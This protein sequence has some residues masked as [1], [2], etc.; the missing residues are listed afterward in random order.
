[1]F[2]CFEQW[3][4]WGWCGPFGRG[5]LPP[6]QE[7]AG[8]GYDPN[9]Y[10]ASAN[11]A[12]APYTNN[13]NLIARSGG[14][15]QVLYP[16]TDDNGTGGVDQGILNSI[17]ANVTTEINGLISSIYPIPL[18]EIGTVCILQVA[19]VTDDSTSAIATVN[20][21]ENGS[22]LTAPATPNAAVYIKP[23]TIRETEARLW[24]TPPFI[25]NPGSGASFT[26]TINAPATPTRQSPVT[27]TAVAIAAGGQ[28]YQVGDILVIV[29]GSSF[30]PDKIVNAS[31]TMCCYELLRRRLAPGEKNFFDEDYKTVKK[32]LL[33]IGNGEMVMDGTYRNF[34]SPAFAWTSESVLQGNSL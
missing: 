20:I 6:R 11:L 23:L 25:R 32:E 13:T 27:V 2:D 17:I 31:T 29:G 3:G 24:Q 18:Q 30:V 26:L 34:F 21:I 4:E 19:T 28:N 1:M 16:A 33:L 14:T 5:G 22:Y 15:L 7:K 8:C 10:I 12:V 9:C